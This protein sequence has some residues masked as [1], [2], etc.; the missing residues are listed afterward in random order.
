MVAFAPPEEDPLETR[1]RSLQITI[2]SVQHLP[3]M[4]VIGKCDPFCVLHFRGGR[5]TTEVKKKTL[6]ATFDASWAWDIHNVME[7]VGALNIG[8]KDYDLMTQDDHVGAVEVGCTHL[9]KKDLL[10]ACDAYAIAEYGDLTVRTKV[11]YNA[12]SAVWNKPMVV[13]MDDPA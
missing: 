10:G 6:D 7:Q 12:Y 9:P 3:K 13:R 2:G 5:E 11:V 4:D 8:V 1:P